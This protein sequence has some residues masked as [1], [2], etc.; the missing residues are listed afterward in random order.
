MTYCYAV[1]GTLKLSVAL[2]I[3]CWLAPTTA[4]SSAACF[5][6]FPAFWQTVADFRKGSS[7]LLEETLVTRKAIIEMGLDG[8]QILNGFAVILS[9]WLGY[10]FGSANSPKAIRTAEKK[11]AM[12]NAAAAAAVATSN[13]TG[14]SSNTNVAAGTVTATSNN[15]GAG[16]GLAASTVT[17]NATARAIAKIP[18]S[19]RLKHRKRMLFAGRTARTSWT[20]CKQRSSL[21]LSS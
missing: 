14:S 8:N 7:K 6:C 10:R 18:V 11:L 21:R 1:Q 2:S 15:I 19:N 17:G 3:S 4:G 16:R 20:D 5:L 13:A 9:F 12:K